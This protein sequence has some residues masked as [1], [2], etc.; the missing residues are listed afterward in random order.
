MLTLSIAASPASSRAEGT[1]R[2]AA[3]PQQGTRLSPLSG[4]YLVG[5][6]A[7]DLSLDKSSDDGSGTYMVLISRVADTSA[8][9]FFG[10]VHCNVGSSM[11][12]LTR[13]YPMTVLVRSACGVGLAGKP[14]GRILPILKWNGSAWTAQES[15]IGRTPLFA[16]WGID[17][18]NIWAVGAHGAIVRWNGVRWSPQPSGTTLELG[19]VGGSD[20]RDLWVGGAEGTLF[21]VVPPVLYDCAGGLI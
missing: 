2:R 15:N 11:L 8:T 21:H 6:Q 10:P 9:L 7:P 14:L 4:L 17:A 3:R 18:C 5:D 16:V 20:A 1:P 13:T 12:V 19:S